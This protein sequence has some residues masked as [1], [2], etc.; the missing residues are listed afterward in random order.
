MKIN[1][2]YKINSKSAQTTG[3]IN[4][5]ILK[6]DDVVIDINNRTLTEIKN[7]YKIVLDFAQNKGYIDM[8]QKDVLDLN[9]KTNI[10]ILNQGHILINYVLNDNEFNYEIKYEEIIYEN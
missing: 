2:N 10:I 1:V 4:G 5:N 6:Y 3:K 7:D 8:G 9:L